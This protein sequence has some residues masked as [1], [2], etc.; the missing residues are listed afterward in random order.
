MSLFQSSHLIIPSLSLIAKAS[1]RATH[2][3]GEMIRSHLCSANV[4]ANSLI[5]KRD[6]SSFVLTFGSQRDNFP[7]TTLFHSWFSV[8][9]V[10]AA[11]KNFSRSCRDEWKRN[12]LSWVSG[13]VITGWI[14][15]SYLS[16]EKCNG[17]DSLNC[18]ELIMQTNREL[19]D[20]VWRKKKCTG[21][22]TWTTVE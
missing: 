20:C 18:A 6:G 22:R 11:A 14:N 15:Q 1:A 4:Q 17:R 10:W 3:I 7:L 19:C 2:Q 9:R 21:K 5:W 12:T 16:H 8:S 13:E